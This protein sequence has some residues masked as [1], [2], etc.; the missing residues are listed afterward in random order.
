MLGQFVFLLGSPLDSLYDRVR[1]HFLS[2]RVK[3][4]WLTKRWRKDERV[5]L[6]ARPIKERHV[7]DSSSD[8]IANTF[9]WA[10]ANVQL[11]FP[12]AA[13]E[14]HRL[15]ADQK[16]FRG[17]IVVLVVV[18]ALLL[19]VYQAGVPATVPY[20]VLILLS[21]WRYVDQRR[22]STSLAYT[23]LLALESLPKEAA[24]PTEG[25]AQ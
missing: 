15:E 25:G 3:S 11:R 4:A 22:K 1:K 5:Y 24:P 12:A 21:F 16:F 9:Q 23:Y 7:R 20:L 13:E 17:L 10:K 8:E 18:C 2:G 6:A 14:I 19:F